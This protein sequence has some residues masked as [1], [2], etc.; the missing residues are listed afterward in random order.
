MTRRAR[1]RMKTRNKVII[2]I[3]TVLVLIIAGGMI[4]GLSIFGKMDRKKITN[5]DKALGI[6]DEVDKKRNVQNILFFGLDNG[7]SDGDVRSD[8]IMVISIDKDNKKIVA[9]SI[10]R[11]SYVPIPG[12][13]ED[14]LNAAYH[15]GGPELAV[16][17]INTNFGL[18]IKDYVRV[19]FSG[20]EKLVDKVGGVNIKLSQL[21]AQTLNEDLAAL[22]Q[23]T[24][25]NIPK[26][27]SGVVKLNGKQALAYSRIRRI[28]KYDFERTQRQRNVID[29]LFKKIKSQ[30]VTKL[31]GTISTMMP[32]V[33]TSLSNTEIFSLASN[34]ISYDVNGLEQHRIPV[35][36]GYKDATRKNLSV[37]I[38]DMDLNKKKLHEFIYG[39]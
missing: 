22:S 39:Q 31:P 1:R 32:L 35:D 24:G 6:S 26:V 30:G 18:D 33:E 21:E 14:K 7:K 8:S 13:G 29:G 34:A 19:D 2:A 38:L 15:L 25:K 23:K 16:K 28:G 12:Y 10:M 36:N 20:L 17:T 9:T 27:N 3:V 37:L 5:D 11:D 4:Y